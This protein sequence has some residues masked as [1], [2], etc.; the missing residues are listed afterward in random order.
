MKIREQTLL[1]LGTIFIILFTVLFLTSAH[2]IETTFSVIE[3]DDVITN[4]LRVSNAIDSK[5]NTLS[6]VAYDY[7][8]WD[9]T[10]YFVQGENEGYI[11][12]TLYPD[13]LTNLDTNMILFYNS[14][15]ELYYATAIDIKSGEKINISSSLLDYISTSDVLFPP[16]NK[17]IAGI[18][19]S[20]EGP[21]L[22]A[23]CP[24][25]Q[26]SEKGPVVGTILFAR[27]FDQTVI[28]ELKTITH[29]NL[30]IQDLASKNEALD[31]DKL[32]AVNNSLYINPK[33]ETLIVGTTVLN[34]LNGNPILTLEVEMVRDA[35]HQ[36]KVVIIHIFTAFVIIGIICGIVLMVLLD[37]LVL[38]RVSLLS[39]NLTNITEKGLISSR[40]DIKGN[41][42]I[43]DLA[44]TI[45]YML[46]SLENNEIENKKRMETV[47]SSVICGV[48]LIDA[49]TH[50]IV[51]VNP[52]ATEIIGLPKEKI[53]GNVSD[54]FINPLQKEKCIDLDNEIIDKCFESMLIDAEG[55][56]I[57]TLVS[58]V[59]VYLSDEKYLVESFVDM[60]QIKET[61]KQLIESEEK[62]VKIST[63]AH[64]AIVMMDEKHL[65]TFW[66]PAAERIF[67][68]TKVEAIGKDMNDLT[69]PIE[70]KSKYKQSL[71]GFMSDNELLK[72]G[73]IFSVNT[74]KKDGTEFPV[75]VSLSRFKL[76]NGSWNI[77][78]IIRDI[79]DRKKA[80]EALL[81]AKFTAEM[82]NRAKSDF[83]AT[84]SHELRTPLNSIIG[85]SDLMLC[86]NAGDMTD[87]QK[88]F[89]GNISTSGKHLLSLIN[90]VL[91][92]SKIEAGRMELN[93]ELFNANVVMEEV[94]QI[95]TPL[96]DKK[97]V[98]LEISKDENLSLIYADR[99]RFKQIFFNLISNA[100]KFTHDGGNVTISSKKIHNKAQFSVKDTGIG[101]SEADKC[102]LFQPF[103]QLDSS[104]TRRYEGTG[105]GLSLVKRFVEM[106]K[107]RIWVE[108][109][110]GK[111]TTFT[112]EL[113]LDSVSKEDIN[114]GV[115]A[116]PAKM[117]TERLMESPT[118][119]IS[120]ITGP[121]DSTGNAPLILIVEDDDNAKE[122][123]EFTLVNEGYRVASAKNGKEALKLAEMMQPMIIILDIMLP[124]MDGWD[125]I[126]NL[127]GNSHTR[128]IPVITTSVLEE[129]EIR[130]FWAAV[131]HLVKPIKK[132]ALINSLKKI[133]TNII[134]SSFKVLVVD[135]DMKQLELT[136]T[137]LSNE[138]FNVLTAH[139]GKEA[140]DAVFR[141]KPDVVVL[142]LMMPDVSGYDVIQVLKTNSETI[143]IPIIICTAKDLDFSEL[144]S[145]KGNVSSA[146]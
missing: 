115:A 59:P 107:G 103:T 123:L 141:E 119:S 92:I 118:V 56:E 73:L 14:S 6:S 39:S 51:D 40:I 121:S 60:T 34:D 97:G 90:N 139:G 75:E 100:I 99:I 129:S 74:R 89:I 5:I 57:P 71:E 130:I 66:N 105:L 140:I 108:S 44:N 81:E 65:I 41:D 11:N 106:H 2:I 94:K 68:Y 91:D 23:S 78:A 53:V 120:K 135:D 98:K 72:R 79:T 69:A 29:I 70:N 87:L 114:I 55:K 134:I 27:Y 42:E 15:R 30:D 88:R 38:D 138:G 4:I 95:V 80:E 35:Y 104:I 18:I 10:F 7:G 131:D 33:N 63:V 116:N 144:E 85:F 117:T 49:K 83:L 142:D 112:F 136:S 82:A 24:I 62:F 48:L 43:K 8:T 3:E 110:V 96:S 143:D 132:E 61:E 54:N 67:G 37:K 9:A 93:Y 113:P 76:K 101:I 31:P 19:N 58:I 128:S 46:E 122:L 12:E 124:C 64:D 145:L 22:I 127:K 111:G 13:V 102:K 77:V 1:F 16:N 17:Q 36:S 109:E 21:L 125:V 84:M 25:T 32:S 26:S 126:S 146:L 47:L 20:P 137:M 50:I 52:K 28:E 133:N 45:N 86:G